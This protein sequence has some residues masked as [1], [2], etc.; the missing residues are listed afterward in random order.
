MDQKYLSQIE[1]ARR[2][3][4]LYAEIDEILLEL[5]KRRGV[6]SSE[7]EK[8]PCCRRRSEPAPIV[9]KVK[10]KESLAETKQ[11]LLLAAFR[12]YR[13]SGT[14]ETLRK[15]AKSAAGVG[16]SRWTVRKALK[17]LCDKGEM[18]FCKHC[19]KGLATGYRHFKFVCNPGEDTSKSV[20]RKRVPILY[21][22]VR[23]EI[24]RRRLGGTVASVHGKTSSCRPSR[25]VVYWALKMLVEEGKMI[26]HKRGLTHIYGF[27][28]TER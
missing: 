8:R 2:L 27:P 19:L 28:A 9:E 22:Q 14:V 24:L 7:I 15:K 12:K 3:A 21:D 25:F 6:M 17:I 13:W 10:K 5:T 16:A 20:K 1:L 4:T 18:S 26:V 23:D 11:D